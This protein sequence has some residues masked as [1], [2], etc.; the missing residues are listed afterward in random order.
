[1]LPTGF[2]ASSR[3][4]RRVWASQAAYLASERAAL[5]DSAGAVAAVL[6]CSR[7]PGVLEQTRG[8][9]APS[10]TSSSYSRELQT[11]GTLGSRANGTFCDLGNF[12]IPP[13]PCPKDKTE[14]QIALREPR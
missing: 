1:M 3:W 11:T 12:V 8:V 2:A 4:V 9:L 10:E 5:R 14:T 6:V 13:P 7:L